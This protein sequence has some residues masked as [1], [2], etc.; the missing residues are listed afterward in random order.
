MH[1]GRLVL[2]PEDTF[3]VPA[4][5]AALLARLR[6]IDFI[7]AHILPENEADYLLGERFM[8]LV[9]FMGCSPYIQLKPTEDSKPFCHLKI[10]GPYTDPVFLGGKNSNAPSCK[11]CRKRIPQWEAL[12][13]A[14]SKQPQRYQAT[15]PHCGNL[16]NPAT[17]NWRQAA[18]TGRFFLLVE[19]I[20]P[21]EAQPSTALL[22]ALQGDDDKAWC[23]FYIQDD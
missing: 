6:G 12:I 16:Q 1:T 23:Y 20:F 3:Y 22:K 5:V 14:W 15:C 11:A 21:Q 10:D 17:Y 19:N 7:G 9:T 18:G 4:D 8:Q 13:N 2:T